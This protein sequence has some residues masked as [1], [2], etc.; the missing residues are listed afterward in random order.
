[1][2]CQGPE[3]DLGSV[4]TVSLLPALVPEFFDVWVV[5]TY[6]PKVTGVFWTDEMV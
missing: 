5:F 4:K 2:Q 1:M 6:F 3:Q